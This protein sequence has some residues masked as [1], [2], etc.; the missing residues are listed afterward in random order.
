MYHTDWG[1]TKRESRLIVRGALVREGSTAARDAM[2]CWS[3]RCDVSYSARERS[4]LA[5]A[6]LRRLLAQSTGVPFGW[7]FDVEICGGPI[8]RRK[9]GGC[10]PS[11]AISHSGGWVACAVASSG[12]IGIDIEVYRPG[13]DIMGIAG[14]AFGDG[15]R[16]DVER[17]GAAAF[18]RIWTLREALAKARGRGLV[19]AADGIDRVEGSPAEGVRLRRIGGEEWWLAH[20]TPVEGLTLALAFRCLVPC[21]DRSISWLDRC[22]LNDTARLRDMCRDAW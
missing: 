8:A 10:L 12:Q 14:L 18:Y 1:T 11:I 15:E 13:R 22:G 19:E 20:A 5:R 17:E 3:R 9:S 6:L 21:S 7:T 16:Q 4:L 2:R